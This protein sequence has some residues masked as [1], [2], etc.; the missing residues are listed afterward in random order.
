[1]A[2]PRATKIAQQSL[3]RAKGVGE[4]LLSDP[5]AQAE[6]LLRQLISDATYLRSVGVMDYSLLMGVHYTKYA[7]NLDEE[8]DAADKFMVYGRG[9]LHLSVL[10]ETMRREGYELQIGQPQVIIKEVDGKKCEPIEELTIDVPEHHSGKVIE[11]VSTRKGNMLT[12]E[13]CLESKEQTTLSG[14]PLQTALM[15]GSLA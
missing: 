4:S 12:M 3:E 5:S 13:P 8:T 1:M 6:N 7:V 15:S 10:I 14:E 11:F 2:I 9:V